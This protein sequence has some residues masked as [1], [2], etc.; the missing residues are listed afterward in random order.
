MS[1]IRAAALFGIPAFTSILQWQKLYN[2][3]GVAAL[4][5]KP[6]GRP[7]MTK[8]KPKI[9]KPPKAVSYTHL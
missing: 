6:R 3:G 9:D 7:K 2:T 1:P 4:M 8:P 5:A